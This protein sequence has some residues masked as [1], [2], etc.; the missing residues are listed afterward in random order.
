[1]LLIGDALHLLTGPTE[2]DKV[3]SRCE[4]WRF[5]PTFCH[6]ASTLSHSPDEPTRC[7]TCKRL[8]LTFG[9]SRRAR[10]SGRSKSQMQVGLSGLDP[11]I[12]R[13]VAAVDWDKVISRCQIWRF[14]PTFCHL[15]STLSRK[16][17]ETPMPNR[18]PTTMHPHPPGKRFQ[19][20]S[21]T[22]IALGGS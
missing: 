11:V 13:R 21:H 8:Y 3:I 17:R 5:C 18:P 6:L 9:P 14:C 19:V 2:W 12:V 10:T 1:M 4:M 20:R 15:A 16:F 7:P 22:K